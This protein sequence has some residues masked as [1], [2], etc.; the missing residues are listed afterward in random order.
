M[1]SSTAAF[2]TP[3]TVRG[4]GSSSHGAGCSPNTPHAQ[5]T[6]QENSSCVRD[7]EFDVLEDTL[8][9]L[10]TEFLDKVKAILKPA[11]SHLL[12]T[13]EDVVS[14]II[15]HGA[16]EHIEH[17]PHQEESEENGSDVFR[18]YVDGNSGLTAYGLLLGDVFCDLRGVFEKH[19]TVRIKEIHEAQLRML[20]RVHI[21]SNFGEK[22][23]YGSHRMSSEIRL[24][25][26]RKTG[27]F[28][29]TSW[30]IMMEI[31]EDKEGVPLVISD[32]GTRYDWRFYKQRAALYQYLGTKTD[33]VESLKNTLQHGGRMN[34]E[35]NNLQRQV[36]QH[37]ERYKDSRYEDSSKYPPTDKMINFFFTKRWEPGTKKYR[38]SGAVLE[39]TVVFKIRSFKAVE[40]DERKPNFCSEYM[41]DNLLR[42]KQVFEKGGA[43]AIKI[44]LDE[45]QPP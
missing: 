26:Y 4:S 36:I 33:R 17:D 19:K 35:Q 21:P 15:T 7:F 24:Q 1:G 3:S 10:V 31:V 39:D 30:I 12:P 41:N 18:G 28:L 8:E 11:Q 45:Y 40:D 37:F 20:R 32:V 9:P 44:E 14:F 5:Q 38:E 2:A 34:A 25:L 27:R 23:V 6:S 13:T 43:C 22:F 16:S 29:G 42:L